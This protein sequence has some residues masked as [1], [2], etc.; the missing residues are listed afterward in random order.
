[1]ASH[2]PL[3]RRPCGIERF[4]VDGVLDTERVH[5]EWDGSWLVASDPLLR[6][7]EL[8]IAVDE[9]FSEAGVGNPIARDGWAPEQFM[10]ALVTSCDAIHLAEYRL[11]GHRRVIT[12]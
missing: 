3:P 10:L 5:A 8:A 4:R 1:M 7:A 9:A 12:L 11:Q 2:V 6:S